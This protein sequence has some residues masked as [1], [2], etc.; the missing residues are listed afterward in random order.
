MSRG[1]VI[2]QHSANLRKVSCSEFQDNGAALTVE[3][4]AG[5]S[6]KQH[7]S[8]CNKTCAC[9][10]GA[11]QG[12]WDCH[13]CHALAQ[14]IYRVRKKNRRRA[15]AIARINKTIAGLSEKSHDGANGE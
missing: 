10:R 6:R 1:V 4:F 3:V 14:S 13:V 7:R 8:T 2:D 9:G 5:V 12:Q 15:E 11:R